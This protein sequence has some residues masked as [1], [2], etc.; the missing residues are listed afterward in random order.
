LHHV[1]CFY[2]LIKKETSVADNGTGYQSSPTA[3]DAACSFNGTV[4][5]D[6]GN[7]FP[8]PISPASPSGGTSLPSATGGAPIYPTGGNGTGAAGPTGAGGSSSNPTGPGAP[9][10]TGAASANKAGGALAV[11]GLAAAAL[12]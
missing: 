10:Y 11:I 2:H 3:G 5:P 6:S 7:T 9:V 12:L 8:V 1:S 4:Y